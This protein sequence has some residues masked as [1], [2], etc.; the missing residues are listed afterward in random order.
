MHSTLRFLDTVAY[1]A[2]TVGFCFLTVCIVSGAIWAE[3][4][5]GRFWSWDPKETWSLITWLIF[6]AYLHARYQRGWRGVGR[7]YSGYWGSC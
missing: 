4:V 5:W 1:Q 3:H 2:V 6:A 7:R